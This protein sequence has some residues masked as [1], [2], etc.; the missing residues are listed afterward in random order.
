MV[1]NERIIEDANATKRSTGRKLLADRSVNIYSDMGAVVHE[2]DIITL[3][4]EVNGFSSL[5][6]SLQWQ[7]D[8][9]MSWTDV[10]GANKLTHAFVATAETI[11]YSWRLSVDVTD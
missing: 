3:T 9:G 8:N 11:N 4:G 7:Y 1:S 5:D 10:P 6:I 2:G